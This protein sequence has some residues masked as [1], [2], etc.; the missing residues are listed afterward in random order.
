MISINRIRR[1]LCLLLCLALLPVCTGAHGEDASPTVRIYLK[2]L[3]LTDRADLHL[4]GLYTAFA[5]NVSMGFPEGSEITLQIRSGSIYLFYE[6]MS[7]SLGTKVQLVQNQS[8]QGWQEGIRFVE[9]GNL[10]PGTLT[11]TVQDG[12]LM[13]VL[14]LT[15]EEYLLGVVPYEMSNS[16]PLEALKAQAICARTYAMAHLDASA[17]YDMVDT[18]ANQVFLGINYS[19]TNAIQAVQETAGVVGGYKGALATCYYAA[20]NGGQTEKVETVW[21]SKG[22][23]SYYQVTDD[24]YDVE[25]PESPVKRARLYKNGEKLPDAFLKLL[26]DAL[27]GEM[28]KRGMDTDVSSLRIDSITAVSLSTPRSTD[29]SKLMTELTITFNWSGRQVLYTPGATAIPAADGDTELSLFASPTPTAVP[30]TM[31]TAEAIATPA[32][33]PVYSVFLPVAD[34]CTLTLKLFPTV[35]RALNLSI[36]G[37]DNEIVTVVEKDDQFVLESRRYG[38]GVGMSQ[39]GAQWM[40]SHYDM[41]YV[42]ILSFYYP[43]MTLMKAPSGSAVLPTAQAELVETPGPAATATPRPTLMPATMTDDL[44]AGSYLAEITGI[45]EDSSVNLR[46]EPN[47]SATVLRRLYLHQQLIVLPDCEEE[48]WAHVKTDVMEGYVM[49]SF[50]QRQE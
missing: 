3:G 41:T 40:A 29:E 19:N 50:L 42:E 43:G 30:E 46:E 4:D 20:S 21:G 31:A 24:P 33:T 15:I 25:N 32:P 17:A 35:L 7:L 39:R 5:S 10:Y 36:Y 44:P 27:Q 26:A 14:A 34:S 13:P 47:T 11:L 9:G 49:E 22:D 16:F 12:Q 37:A 28:T 48:G 23:W 18:T 2:R 45:D 38:H 8:A 6:G 1:F